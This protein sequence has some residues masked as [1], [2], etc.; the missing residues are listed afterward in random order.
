MKIK[1]TTTPGFNPEIHECRNAM[2]L[3]EVLAKI[4]SLPGCFEVV[5]IEDSPM[6]GTLTWASNN[7]Y[8]V[9]AVELYH[10][11]DLPDALHGNHLSTIMKMPSLKKLM[12]GVMYG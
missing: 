2:E 4:S 9:K 1:F 7:R 3:R 10:S 11:K 8:V 12:D 5:V 6:D